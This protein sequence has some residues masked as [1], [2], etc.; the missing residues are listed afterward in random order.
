MVGIG[1][2]VHE[3]LLA[4]DGKNTVSEFYSGCFFGNLIAQGATP[5]KS[6]PLFLSAKLPLL[7]IVRM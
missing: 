6:K 1:G 3:I 2:V 7:N 4:Q 5:N